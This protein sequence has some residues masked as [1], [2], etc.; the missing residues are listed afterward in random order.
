MTS[1]MSSQDRQQAPFTTPIDS[2]HQ[3]IA[4]ATTEIQHCEQRLVNLLCDR[5]TASAACADYTAALHDASEIQTLD[6]SSRLGFLC[7]GNI[8]RQ[9]GR[10]SAAIEAYDKGLALPSSSLEDHHQHVYDQLRCN[11]KDAEYALNK[12]ID[13]ITKLPMEIVRYH[14]LPKI[15]GDRRWDAQVGCPYLYVSR[16]WR[17]RVL[18]VVGGFKFHMGSPYQENGEL[19]ALHH[20]LHHWML[21]TITL[22]PMITSISSMRWTFYS[23]ICLDVAGKLSRCVNGQGH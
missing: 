23:L 9:Q 13:F 3:R 6:P 8:Y 11:K 21:T 20:M 19:Y 12:Q 14:I 16:A 22:I 15:M 1:P 7:Q 2:L 4:H 10:Q 17:Q 5:A 18:E